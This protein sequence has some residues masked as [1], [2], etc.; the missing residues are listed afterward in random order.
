MKKKIKELIKSSNSI[1][2]LSHENP[3]GDAIGSMIGFYHILSNMSKSVDMVS[4]RISKRFNCLNGIE[5]I[6][7]TS[8]KSYDLGI[9]L[10]CATKE[11]IYQENDIFSRCKQTISI[12]HHGKNT[13]FSDIN[14]IDGN[15]SSCAQI[16]YY[17]FKEWNLKIDKNIAES[18]MTGLLTDTNGFQNN[19]VDKDSYLM[20]A[21][22]VDMG[23]DVYTLRREVLAKITRP[24]NDLMKITLNHLEF[25]LDNKIAFSYISKE[26]MEKS[27]YEPGDHEGLVDL[28]RNIEGVEVSIFMREENGY[29]I[30]L[31]SNNDVNVCNIAIRLGG[32]GHKNAAGIYLDKNFKETKELIINETIKEFNHK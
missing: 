27:N 26:D 5:K 18:L 15:I 3:D 22:I 30:S 19:N 32:N 4:D 2:L 23:V 13:L 28:G 21:D 10:D 11:R 24:Q 12:D 8:N 17:L 6:K 20:A 1:I 14:Y 7:P 16:L 25:Y 29:R 9:V 31:R